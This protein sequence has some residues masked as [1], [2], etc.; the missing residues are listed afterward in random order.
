M[1]NLPLSWGF[2][3]IEAAVGDVA[4]KMGVSSAAVSSYRKRLIDA[5]LVESPSYGKLS[6]AIPYMREHLRMHC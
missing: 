1:L 5:G 6:F 3:E 2:D 4:E